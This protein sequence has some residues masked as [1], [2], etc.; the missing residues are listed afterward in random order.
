MREGLRGVLA[1][2]DLTLVRYRR[3]L[4]EVV[5]E[6]WLEVRKRDWKLYPATGLPATQEPLGRVTE[7]APPSGSFRGEDVT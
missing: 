5:T 4:P 3:T 6:V 1:H 2:L 7:P